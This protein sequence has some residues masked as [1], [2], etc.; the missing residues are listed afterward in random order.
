M[1]ARREPV[2]RAQPLVG[3]RGHFEVLPLRHRNELTLARIVRFSR[4][5]SKDNIRHLTAAS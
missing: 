3:V 2:I 4:P 1:D 5:P